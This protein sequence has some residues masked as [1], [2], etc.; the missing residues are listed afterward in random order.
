LRTSFLRLG[1]LLLEPPLTIANGPEQLRPRGLAQHE[2]QECE[3]EQGP[4]DEPPVDA[5]WVRVG[6]GLLTN[7]R[8]H[9]DDTQRECEPGRSR[10]AYPSFTAEERREECCPSRLPVFRT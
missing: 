3:Y 4:E 8:D 5:Q 6:R 10:H 2:K 7:G 9:G 1:D